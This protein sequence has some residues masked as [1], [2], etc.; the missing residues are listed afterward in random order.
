MMPLSILFLFT[1]KNYTK[2]APRRQ[3]EI[4]AFSKNFWCV[5]LYSTGFASVQFVSPST[6]TTPVLFQKHQ[7][8]TST[9]YTYPLKSIS[10]LPQMG[11]NWCHSE[12]VWLSTELLRCLLS[13]EINS[14]TSFASLKNTSASKRAKVFKHFFF[15]FVWQ[16]TTTWQYKIW[17]PSQKWNQYGL[18]LNK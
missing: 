12:E 18:S 11:R 6:Y 14:K 2:G 3:R 4:T 7:H 13:L 5:T 10:L 8:L 9:S 16:E 15:F 17:V 1:E